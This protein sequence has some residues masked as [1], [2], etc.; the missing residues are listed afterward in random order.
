MS[1]SSSSSSSSSNK[2]RNKHKKKGKKHKKKKGKKNKSNKERS[3]RKAAKAKAKAAKAKAEE[4]QKVKE[5]ATNRKIAA[6]LE[7]KLEDCSA[8]AASL[9]SNAKFVELASIRHAIN[10]FDQINQAI[11]HTQRTGEKLNVS[12]DSALKMK[13]TFLE[14]HKTISTMFSAMA[15]FDQRM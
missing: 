1:T 10:E 13:S 12:F 8:K 7:K 14:K 5:H 6:T 3:K 11:A 2:K 15:K 4:N 9:V